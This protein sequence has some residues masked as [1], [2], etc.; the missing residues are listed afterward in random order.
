[1]ADVEGP[2]L[3]PAP[4]CPLG[5]RLAARCDAAAA[6]SYEV[7]VEW[8]RPASSR[9]GVVNTD[10]LKSEDADVHQTPPSKSTSV[11]RILPRAAASVDAPKPVLKSKFYGAFAL[12]H[13]IILH[14]IDVTPARWRD[15]VD[16][17]PL[18]EAR[19]TRRTG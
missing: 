3:P 15:D 9:I 14:A 12:N 4:R 6:A 7:L 18:D 8:P 17:S 19:C 2:E 10:S 11:D 1:M 13:R 5:R 16:S